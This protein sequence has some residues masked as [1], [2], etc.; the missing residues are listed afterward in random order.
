MKPM[1]IHVSPIQLMKNPKFPNC[2]SLKTFVTL[3]LATLVVMSQAAT[4]Q[5]W[6]GGG[7]NSQWSTTANWQS[8]VVPV[9]GDSVVILLTNR[10]ASID[11]I[12]TLTSLGGITYMTNGFAIT[13]STNGVSLQLGTGGIIVT[14]SGPS[15]A[16]NTYRL[17]TLLGQNMSVINYS[18]SS[19][20]NFQLAPSYTNTPTMFDN[21]GYTLTFD[22]PGNVNLTAG[23]PIRGGG[24]LVKNGTGSLTINATNT[25]YSGSTT[26][27]AGSLQFDTQ[28]VLSNTFTVASGAQFIANRSTTN[29]LTTPALTLGTVGGGSVTN[30]FSLNSLG[31]PSVPVVYATNLMTTGTVYVSITGSGFSVGQFPLIQYQGT[32]GGNGFTFVT[33]ALPAGVT[34]YL[35]NNVQSVDFVITAIPNLLWVG[36]SNNIS[37]GTWDVAVTP[38][39]T[40]LS[41]LAPDVFQSGANV[42]FDDTAPGTTA[43]NL[44]TNVSPTSVLVS[45][46]LLN[47]SFT[48]SSG[49]GGIAILTKAGTGTLTMSVSNSYSGSTTISN[50]TFVLG[51]NNAI[52]SGS[53]VTLEG[54]LNLAGYGD[55]ISALNGNAGVITNSGSSASVLTVGNGNASGT[56]A[57]KIN[58]GTATVQLVK[59][60]TGSQQLGNANA[61][62]G[63]TVINNGTVRVSDNNSLGSGLLTINAGLSASGST[64]L[65]IANNLVIN[66]NATLGDATFNGVLT[67][68]GG[69]NLS[70]GSQK[71]LTVN[72][73][74]IMTGTI[75]NGS[76]A[77]SGGS[78]LTLQGATAY[79]TNNTEVDLGILII[80]NTSMIVSNGETRVIASGANSIARLV[81]TNGGS[82]TQPGNNRFR[83]GFTGGNATGTNIADVAGWINLQAT[84]GAF[85]QVNIGHTAEGYSILNLLSNG[86]ITCRGVVPGITGGQGEFDFNGGTL[87]ANSSPANP[88]MSGLTAAYVQAGGGTIDTAGQNISISQSL[89]DG[90]GGGHLIKVGTFKLSFNGTN[91]YTG[92]TIVSN[93]G[94]GGIGTIVGPLVITSGP[95]L[96]PGD[97]PSSIGT[98]TVSNT[99]TLAAGSTFHVDINRASS[100]NSDMLVANSIMANGG[101]LTFTNRGADLQAGDTFSFFSGPLTGS[102]SVTNLPVLNPG[103]AWDTSLLNSGTITVVNATPVPATLGYTL[104]S[105]NQAVLTWPNGQ[106]WRLLTQT[107]TL[108]AGLSTN[109]FEITGVTSPF[110]NGIDLVNPSVFFKLVYP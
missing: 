75:T 2:R 102:F 57:G 109:W 23:S 73:P 100:P 13:T 65:T 78:Q 32:I 50:G 3:C 1:S 81:I 42:R 24:A 106:G 69:V 8:G 44:A 85:G 54:V 68:N 31:N 99:V 46:S 48:G 4:T 110:T 101:A 18:T 12:T 16:G 64:A 58:D 94:F 41:T 28:N 72:S 105:G 66:G 90:G 22:G 38:N 91:T 14:N 43:V 52:P 104:I 9:N 95:N 11:A 10:T 82:I 26:V 79:F 60:G 40:N 39:W 49:I 37:V 51:T 53:S 88:F 103:L 21:Q 29:I 93:G 89:L 35:S 84:S 86:L 76:M 55:S 17:K 63:G 61:Y 33:N 36:K 19:L 59:T 34:G 30:V 47:Y 5:Y 67:F 80:N 70:G 25:L 62:S 71:T 20:L 7:A 74:V 108:A 87:Q 107:N 27:N 15:T 45:N 6:T 83:L 56:F 96:D 98:F 77:V 97:G 92:S